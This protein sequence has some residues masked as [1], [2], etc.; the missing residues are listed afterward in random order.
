MTLWARRRM[1]LLPILL[2]MSG[3]ALAGLSG[4]F[5]EHEPGKAPAPASNTS[6][7]FIVAY[8]T[9]AEAAPR[10]REAFHLCAHETTYLVAKDS[11]G[12]IVFSGLVR[13]GQKLK[14]EGRAPFSID[15]AR[16]GTAFLVVDSH[17][18]R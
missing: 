9:H 6:F 10:P 14:L 1:L 2:F 3:S 17:T 8:P 16:E 11:R 18:H 4:A 15:A 13:A 7:R 12:L 5:W